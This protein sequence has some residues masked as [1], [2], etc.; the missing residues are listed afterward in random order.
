MRTGLEMYQYCLDNGFGSGYNK[1]NSV[2]HFDIVA[3]NLKQDEDVL[4]AFIGLHNYQSATKHDNNC[5][6]VITNK[7]IMIA[8]KKIIGE[9]FQIVSLENLNDVTLNSGM[10][11]GVIVFDT[12]KERFNVAV[13]KDIANNITQKLHDVL[14]T[15]KSANLA[16][17]TNTSIGKSVADEI[18]ELK[19]LLDDGLITIQEFEQQKKKVLSR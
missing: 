2:N 17:N 18:R 10:I 13:A 3:K 15:S 8:Q 11:F 16:N 9:F 14:F 5:A 12:I 19:Q 1:K 6:Y 4:M 7:R